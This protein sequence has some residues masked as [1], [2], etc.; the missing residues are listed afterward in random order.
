MAKR[1]ERIDIAQNDVF[2]GIK[3]SAKKAEMEV[4]LLAKALKLVNQGIDDVKGKAKGMQSN[5]IPTDV[6][7]IKEQNQL[8]KDAL[9]LAKE[10]ERLE[11]LKI[12]TAQ[13]S[14]KAEADAIRLQ[15]LKN[16]ELE[17]SEARLRKEAK[18][19]A[20]ANSAYTKASNRLNEL[21]KSYKDLAVAGN[22]NS[23]E[24][25]KMKREIDSLDKTL[26]RVDGNVGQFQRNV[27]NYSSAFG[28]LSGVLGTFGIGL[29]VG[30]VFSGVKNFTIEMQQLNL[31]ASRLGVSSENLKG[32]VSEA[33]SLG[34][35]FGTE[36]NDNMVAVN[37]L[38]KEFGISQEQ[39]FKLLE[40][41][42]LS[43]AN[44]QGDMLDSIKE[45]SSQV[46]ASGGDAN[47][48]INILNRSGKEGIFSDK[49][50]DVVKEFGL[51][52]REQT[53]ATSK[54]MN[55]AFGKEFTSRIF[56][57]IN[58]GSMTSVQAL[59]E[60]SKKMNDATIPTNKLQTVIAD[61]FGGAGEDAGLR[62]IQTLTDIGSAT[63]DVVDKTDPY[64]RQQL[65][66]KRLNDELVEAQQSLYESLGGTGAN[67]EQLT[68]K[69][70]VLFFQNILPAIKIVA[71]LTASFVAFKIIQ[72]LVN[73]NF[74]DLAKNFTKL[75]TDSTE[76]TSK[77]SGFGNALKGIGWSVAIGLAVQLG[78]KL[79]DIASGAEAAR[80]AMRRYEAQLK[81]SNEASQ[82]KINEL[83]EREKQRIAELNKLLKDRRISQ[84]QYVKLVEEAEKFTESELRNN[85]K[86][87]NERKQRF[88]DLKAELL[89]LQK[90]ALMQVGLKKNASFVGF[91][92]L[93]SRASEIA[94]ELN[95]SGNQFLGFL[96]KDASYT[97]VLAQLEANI[98][99][100]NKRLVNY[101]QALKDISDS[102]KDFTKKTKG[103]TI[104]TN[105]DTEAIKEKTKAVT[106]LQD[107]VKRS[108]DTE[109]EFQNLENETLNDQIQSAQEQQLNNIADAGTYTID[110]LN[111]L[112][113]K[114]KELRLAMINSEFTDNVAG[115]MNLDLA[116]AKRNKAIQDLDEETLKSRK[117]MLR[118]L[119]T[120]QEEFWEI[121]RL[122][123]K[124]KNEKDLEDEKNAL[125]ERRRMR[126]E[127]VDGVIDE[128]NRISQEE[129]KLIDDRI[130]AEQDLQSN[131]QAQASAGNISAQQSI[132]ASMEAE[133]RA[134]LEKQKEQRK[135]QA[136]DDIKTLYNLINSN[137][138]SGDGV[139]I[140]TTKAIA[141]MGVIKS[142]AKVFSALTGFAKGTEWRLGDEHKPMFGGVDGH[143]VRVD[144]SEA[145][146]KGSL[147]D[148]AE[149]AGITSTSELVQLAVSQKLQPNM[150]AMN[151][152]RLNYVP[153][154]VKQNNDLSELK[155]E[156]RDIKDTIK[157]KTEFS[158]DPYV[159]N[160]MVK[161]IVETQKTGNFSRKNIFK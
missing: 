67:I 63:G 151:D 114:Q 22:E 115:G 70:K 79:Y 80:D 38:I 161:G 41:G 106:E 31:Q 131:L 59:E 73:T 75:K 97:Q 51:R 20:D 109:I 1:I 68:L 14:T 82:L 23:T 132:V 78:M 86:L 121:D 96:E 119:E 89:E 61:T 47:T 102:E 87:A 2:E 9:A 39:A 74:R 110:V 124:S 36:V 159:L 112:I 45:Y 10:R 81:T 25:R 103:S 64:V 29:G 17:K 133:K 136:L 92:K 107:K 153:V 30:A 24:A 19:Q 149:R 62:F 113:A 120:A 88:K 160:G 128:M 137:I 55:D 77:M 56:K 152:D 66:M 91:E 147:M 32:F 111:E 60:V 157:N 95:I 8:Q 150:Y 139:G 118:E 148:K 143:V 98:G 5:P 16:K 15:S 18:A 37:T 43:G 155:R 52:I 99:G 83:Q 4:D 117:T 53:S 12:Q 158:I 140:A 28:K 116:E 104:T 49:G 144:S 129:E 156:L 3:E 100:I 72:G 154:A 40:N 105:A 27:G 135:Q 33:K 93:Q 122:G 65:E 69:A 123:N 6:K 94:K 13:Q 84:S 71:K 108:R 7:G 57:G 42:Y 134:T 50:V 85:K 76:A 126:K 58:D 142:V 145:I 54:A 11:K 125:D 130:K 34:Q 44:A 101:S 21:R 46:R 26:K 141:S 127:F 146:V 138:S 90:Q 48:L 35:T